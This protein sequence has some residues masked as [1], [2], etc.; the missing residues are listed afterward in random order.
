[1]K[2]IKPT[3][4][5]HIPGNLGLPFL[6]NFFPFIKDATQFYEGR[7]AKHG[8]IFKIKTPWGLSVVLC[9]PMANK[10]IL[11]ENGKATS[12][13]EAWEHSIGE[14]FPNGLMLMDGEQHK[15]HRGIMQDA[16][17]KEPIQGYVDIMPKIIINEIAILRGK[18]QI[19]AFPF[20]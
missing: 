1:M 5:K 20:F 10:L 19:L 9:H 11:V 16:F 4:L 12:N 8:D 17:K 7:K 15:Y 13:Q 2:E 18:E 6:G 14:L 3:D